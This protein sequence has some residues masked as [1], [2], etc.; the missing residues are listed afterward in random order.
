M[1]WTEITWYGFTFKGPLYSFLRID[2]W[3]EK[4][5]AEPNII[6][7]HIKYGGGG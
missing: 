4:A 6:F 7:Y 2:Y 3:T 1:I 5:A